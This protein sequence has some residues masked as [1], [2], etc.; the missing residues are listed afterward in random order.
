MLV[1]ALLALPLLSSAHGNH[2]NDSHSA[3]KRLP[4]SWFHE[5]D[6]PV[7]ELFRRGDTDGVTYAAVGSSEWSASFP[8]SWPTNGI[9][10]NSLPSSWVAALNAA[11]AAKTIPDVPVP[12]MGSDGNPAYPS[13]Q[14]PTGSDICSGTYGCRVDGDIWDGPDGTATY[15]PRFRSYAAFTHFARKGTANLLTFLEGNNQQV[16]HFLIGS[17]ILYAGAQFSQ[18]VNMSHDIA[19]HTWTHPYMTTQSNLQVVGELGWTMQLI[20]NST[21]GRIPKYWRPPYGDTDKRVSAIAKEVFGLTTIVWNQDTADWTLT[22]SNPYT[23]PAQIQSNMET[24]LSGSKSPG[25]IILEH[26]LS[27]D[28]TAAFIAAYPLMIDPKNGWKV[29][30]LVSLVSGN[31]SYQNAA[32]N[33]SPVTENDIINAKNGASGIVA[34]AAGSSTAANAGP[35]GTTTIKSTPG[36]VKAG[37]TGSDSSSAPSTTASGKSAASPRWAMSPTGLITVAAMLM[38]WT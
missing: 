9:D 36:S 22:E 20:H 17:N 15:V 1:L 18:M 35:S 21:G 4:S 8:A 31:V 13:G 12:T 19:V 30:S 24:W 38:L 10:T 28:S 5:R 23:T 7:H 2:E 34:A 27:T 11:V 16:T 37:A 26:E 14:D 25:L 6:H 29:E 3:A 33:F 32:N